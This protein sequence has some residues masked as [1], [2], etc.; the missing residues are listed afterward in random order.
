MAT[1][2][3]EDSPGAGQLRRLLSYGRKVFGLGSGLGRVVDVR[4]APRTSAGHVAAAVFYTGLLRIRSFNA[5]EPRLGEKPFLRLVGAAAERERLCS[6]DTVG[7]SLCGMDL[8]SVSES[9]PA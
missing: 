5:L 2:R 4:R 8:D 6:V 7:R 1:P 9:P 3:A